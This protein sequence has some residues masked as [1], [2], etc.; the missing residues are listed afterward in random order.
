MHLPV[1]TNKPPLSGEV[2]SRSDDGE[3][4]PACAKQKLPP[5][6]RAFAESGAANAVPLHD[7]SRENSVWS[8]PQ[9]ATNAK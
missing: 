9:A 1:S 5:Q 2:A 4:S 6:R 3:G 8:G 7:P